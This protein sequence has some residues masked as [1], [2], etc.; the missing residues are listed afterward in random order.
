MS[1]TQPIGQNPEGLWALSFTALFLWVDWIQL[2]AAQGS[3]PPCFHWLGVLA[4]E[5][6]IPA[7]DLAVHGRHQAFPAMNR[8]TVESR[9]WLRYGR[10]ISHGIPCSIS[11][12]PPSF[13]KRLQPLSYFDSH[14][15]CAKVKVGY[16]LVVD[17]PVLRL[18]WPIVIGCVQVIRT[19]GCVQDGE[20]HGV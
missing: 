1:C 6:S 9:L 19:S 12:E 3:K 7:G 18:P 16:N 13:L 14:F 5:T 2:M 20:Y 10:T 15:L 11:H 17:G 8:A 4:I